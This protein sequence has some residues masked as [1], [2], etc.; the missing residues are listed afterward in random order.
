M[1]IMKSHTHQKKKTKPH[2]QNPNNQNIMKGEKK[3]VMHNTM[4]KYISHL[5]RMKGM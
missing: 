1:I 3:Q 2:T 5:M 4:P